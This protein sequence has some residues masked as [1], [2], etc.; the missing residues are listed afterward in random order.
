MK[1]DLNLF[2]VFDAI[3]C[4]GNITKAAS[5][6]NLSQPAVSHSLGKLRT[7]FDDALFIR[8]GNEM[9]PTPVAKNVIADVR[10][11]LHQLQVCLVQ[12]RQFEPL[13]SRKNFT[14]S[15]H[16]SLEPYYL[17]ILMESLTKESPSINLRS[18]VRVRRTELENKLASGDIDLAID[19]LFPVSNNIMHTKL[20]QDQLVVVA[21]K[22]HPSFSKKLDLTTYLSLDHVLVSSRSSGPGVEDFELS[23]LGVHRNIALRCQHALAA[24]RVI[25]G[26]DMLLTLPR[27]SAKMYSEM[28][29]I[30]IFEMPVELP[31]IDVHLYWHVNVDKDP[32]N[33]WLRNKMIMAASNSLMFK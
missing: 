24:C 1:I 11:A 18:N 12:S 5:V 4:E 31:D 23:R 7:Y 8:Q 14:L 26:N 20:E 15:M 27:I 28:L 17:P 16:G 10:E 22:N 2:I 32:A 6:L 29:D 3:Y 33:K 25:L 21:R 13:T 19:A 9:R 30:S